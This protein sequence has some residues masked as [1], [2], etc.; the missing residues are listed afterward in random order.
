MS[1]TFSIFAFSPWSDLAMVALLVIAGVILIGLFCGIFYTVY[2]L[3]SLPLRRRER[4]RFFLDLLGHGLDRGHSAQHTILSAAESGDRTLGR[5]F[6]ILAA[7]FRTGFTLSQ[8]LGSTPR[9]LPAQIT[10]MLEAGE[11]TGD[12]RKVL[13]ACRS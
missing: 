13:P 12:I 4:A 10:A 1:S 5:Q 9:L 8:A 3:I 11:E 6:Q 2:Y 7:R